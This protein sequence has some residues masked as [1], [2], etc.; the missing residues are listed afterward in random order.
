[1]IVQISKIA[2]SSYLNRV[3]SCNPHGCKVAPKSIHAVEIFHNILNKFLMNL[4]TKAL[5]T[6]LQSCC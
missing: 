3:K 6:I 5:G 1:M 2:S 4:S